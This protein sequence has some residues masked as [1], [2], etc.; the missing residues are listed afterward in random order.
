MDYL[1]RITSLEIVQVGE[2]KYAMQIKPEIH[3]KGQKIRIW[4]AYSRGGYAH[5]NRHCA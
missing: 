1:D 5:I 3:G 4:Q 2:D